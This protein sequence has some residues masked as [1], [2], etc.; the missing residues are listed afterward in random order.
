MECDS[1]CR[2]LLLLFRYVDGKCVRVL[3]DTRPRG[4]VCDSHKG[5]AYSA[6]AYIKPAARMHELS[7][8]A[9]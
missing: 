6:H 1:A 5:V 7:N 4:V 9:T 3:F 8:E 2:G